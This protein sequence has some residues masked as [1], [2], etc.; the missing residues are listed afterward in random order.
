MSDRTVHHHILLSNTLLVITRRDAG[1]FGADAPAPTKGLHELV[2]RAA[3]FL[4]EGVSGGDSPAK[5]P[6]RCDVAVIGAQ[7][8]WWTRSRAGAD[9]RVNSCVCLLDLQG[10]Q[11]KLLG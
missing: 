2:R 9:K 1:Y 6:E 5:M 11:R 10:A 8:S 4:E 7:T 3:G